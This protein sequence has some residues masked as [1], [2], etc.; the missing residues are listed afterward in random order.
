MN[1]RV[2][3]LGI[4]GAVAVIL[5][6]YAMLWRPQSSDLSDAKARQRSAAAQN[7][8]LRLQKAQLE[9]SGSNRPALES[10]LAALKVAVPDAPNLAEFIL[11]T[12]DAA[13]ASGIDVVS[14]TPTPPAADDTSDTP[15]MHVQLDVTGGYFQVIDFLNRLD[16]LPRIIVIDTLTVTADPEASGPPE[17]TASI[18][19]RLFLTTATP[20]AEA[21]PPD[22]GS[23]TTTTTAGG[24]TSSSTTSSS[25][26]TSTSTTEAP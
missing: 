7:R 2:L 9:E 17:L 5:L 12:N 23:T 18:G 4:F 8:L 24:A 16:Q 6:W 13:A 14:I 25:V 20:V 19:G 1:R 10:R 22:S 26:D 3:L 11:D 15:S 21:P